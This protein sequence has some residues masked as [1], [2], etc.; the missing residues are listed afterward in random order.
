[1]R[2]KEGLSV[3][4]LEEG[5]LDS[6]GILKGNPTSGTAYGLSDESVRLFLL[7]AGAGELGLA[8]S[9]IPKDL[10]AELNVHLLPLELQQL[11]TWERDNRGRLSYLVLTWKGEEALQ[12][13]K[14]PSSKASSWAARRRA[15]VSANSS[16]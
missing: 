5:M 6:S 1:M 10:R 4:L 2:H 9:R 11:V 16:Q 12:A 8:Q 13:A 14:T 3:S 15:S 7:I